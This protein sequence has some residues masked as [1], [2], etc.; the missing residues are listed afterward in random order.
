MLPENTFR[1]FY[2]DTTGRFDMLIS[3]ENT[4]VYL[5]KDLP[6]TQN[7]Y[8]LADGNAD[9]V[10]RN[11]SCTPC[12]TLLSNISGRWF[13]GLYSSSCTHFNFTVF[14]VSAGKNVWEISLKN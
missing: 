4:I 13:I 1:F 8:Q 7:V 6:P 11:I 12:S 5:R 14:V 9:I 3:A 10:T 2:F